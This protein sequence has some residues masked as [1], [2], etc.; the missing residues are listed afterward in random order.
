MLRQLHLLMVMSSLV[1]L[2]WSNYNDTIEEGSISINGYLENGDLEYGDLENGDLENG[3]LE[4]GDLENGDLENGDLE[5]RHKH[6]DVYYARKCYKLYHY[7]K[8][9]CN[10]ELFCK[11]YGGHLATI[12]NAYLNRK[13]AKFT[14][15]NGI[16]YVWIGLLKPCIHCNADFEW[17]WVNGHSVYR[18]WLHG[19]PDKASYTSCCAFMHKYY[20]YKWIP[21]VCSYALPFW[22]VN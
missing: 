5:H 7:R 11:H 14:K 15:C 13:L 9:F 4:N 2:V 17:N 1:V 18:N 6:C 10:A 20:H 8:N 22:C 12:Q 19:Y 3:D 16:S 21:L